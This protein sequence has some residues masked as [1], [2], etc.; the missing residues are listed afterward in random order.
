LRRRLPPASRLQAG[1]RRLAL[2]ALAL[3]IGTVSLA[4]QAAVDAAQALRE[5]PE[6]VTLRH[7]SARDRRPARPTLALRQGQLSLRPGRDSP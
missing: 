6:G 4:E 2:F 7:G 1:V 5:R 3:P